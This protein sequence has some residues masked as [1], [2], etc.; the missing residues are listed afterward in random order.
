[1]TMGRAAALRTFGAAIALSLVLAAPGSQACAS[2]LLQQLA[3]AALARLPSVTPAAMKL[4]GG[5]NRRWRIAFLDR[6]FQTRAFLKAGRVEEASLETPGQLGLIAIAFPSC[7]DLARAKTAIAR[8]QRLIFRTP[9]LSVFRAF[10]R[11]TTLLFLV[12]ETPTRPE[13]ARLL[14]D[15]P[16]SFRP[17]DAP[18]PA[19]SPPPASR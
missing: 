11:G 12:S 10:S 14:D 1:M 3:D 9:I 2:V 7:V 6:D 16:A 15:L 4:D 19:L 5:A 8:S 18:C 13:V 17:Q